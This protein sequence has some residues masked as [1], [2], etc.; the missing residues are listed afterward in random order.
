MLLCSSLDQEKLQEKAIYAIHTN[1]K[2]IKKASE[3]FIM[4]FEIA[5]Q[6]TEDTSFYSTEI[7]LLP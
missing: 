1:K 4:W 2:Y 6:S 7:E 3:F 5:S